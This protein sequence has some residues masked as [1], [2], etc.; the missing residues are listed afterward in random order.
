MV[1]GGCCLAD[2]NWSFFLVNCFWSSSFSLSLL[3]CLSVL[4]GLLSAYGGADVE[5]SD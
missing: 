5:D 2:G 1:N 3:I 4:D